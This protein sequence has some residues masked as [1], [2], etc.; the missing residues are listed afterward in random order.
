MQADLAFSK[1]RWYPEALDAYE[2]LRAKHWESFKDDRESKERL[3]LLAQARGAD[4]AFTSLHALDVARRDGSFER[5]ETVVSGY[6]TTFVASLAAKEMAILSVELEQS[7]NED[8][9]DIF[10]M[11]KALDRC[12]HPAAIAQ[13]KME[14]GS[15]LVIEANDPARARALFQEVAQSDNKK[16]AQ[17][18][19]ASLSELNATD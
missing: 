16:L 1:L 12:T 15:L 4:S 17:F 2:A 5:L 7:S 8:V 18:A 9:T 11:E 19:R 14:L 3:D 6:P 10:A 13:L